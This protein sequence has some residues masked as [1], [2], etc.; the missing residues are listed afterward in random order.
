VAAAAVEQERL[1]AWIMSQVEAG[2]ALPG[3]Y[4]PNAQ[5]LER[6]REWVEAEA[7]SGAGG[8]APLRT[9]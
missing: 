8:T 4:P 3:L 1:E 6:Y 9:I 7:A 5:N 2:L